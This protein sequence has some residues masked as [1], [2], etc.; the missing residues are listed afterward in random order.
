MRNKPDQAL[1]QLAV[2]QWSTNQ[3]FLLCCVHPTLRSLTLDP[4]RPGLPQLRDHL[5]D[6]R[7]F[8]FHVNLTR[9][10]LLPLDRRAVMAWFASR[11]VA[12]LNAGLADL[13]KRNLQKLCARAGVPSCHARRRGDPAELLVVKPNNNCGGIGERA[14]PKEL[15]ARLKVTV[16]AKTLDRIKLFRRGDIADET[17][18]DPS[19]TV[20]RYIHND[21]G[22]HLRAF[23]LGRRMVVTEARSPH[24]YK[25]INERDV[26]RYRY[27]ADHATRPESDADAVSVA[28]RLCRAIGL[29]FG[30]I[31]LMQSADGTLYPVDVN[32][33]PYWGGED[34]DSKLVRFLRRGW[35]HL[36]A[37]KR[38]S[39]L[40]PAASR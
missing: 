4:L 27:A 19:L 8:L 31:D 26:T 18:R 29:D 20:E 35:R 7:L 9:Q 38:R 11:N 12:V 14:L 23:V 28:G 10:D 3:N 5:R 25:E 13:G 24:L 37:D 36:A 40:A 16:S 22:R 32:P 1:P 6:E 39:G 15:A 2:C 17:W 34:R 33:T 21:D 30:A